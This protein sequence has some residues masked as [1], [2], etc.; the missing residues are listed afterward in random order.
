MCLVFSVEGISGYVYEMTFYTDRK[1]YPESPVALQLSGNKK[2][3]PKAMRRTAQ[4]VLDLVKNCYPGTHVCFDELLSS[5]E[6]VERLE[7]KGLNYICTIRPN[8]L[9]GF[10]DCWMTPEREFCQNH[11]GFNEELYNAFKKISVVAWKAM[12]NTRQLLVSNCVGVGKVSDVITWCKTT[13]RTMRIKVPEIVSVYKRLMDC[14]H[15]SEKINGLHC[16][17]FRWRKLDKRLFVKIFDTVICNAWL[18]YRFQTQGADYMTLHRFRR[19]IAT[20]LLHGK[21]PLRTPVLALELRESASSG[22]DYNPLRYSVVGHMPELTT[23]NEYQRC[24]YNK[25]C[26]GKTPFSCKVCDVYLCLN[27]KNMCFTQ[28]HAQRFSEHGIQ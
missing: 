21:T 4:I 19:Q 7:A 3:K 9:Q 13:R 12:D 26:K 27:V 15:L 10:K 1:K 6:L 11:R 24:V 17:P 23:E 20:A 28:Y 25:T 16:T 8:R 22:G 14:F 5:F 2:R 18:L